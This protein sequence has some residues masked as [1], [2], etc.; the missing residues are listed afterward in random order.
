VLNGDPWRLA[1][2]VTAATWAG[3]YLIFGVLLD[4]PL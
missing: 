2:S 4:V 3:L 1:I